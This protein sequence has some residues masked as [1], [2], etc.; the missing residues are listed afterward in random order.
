MALI[1]R[2][3]KATCLK[4]DGKKFYLDELDPKAGRHEDISLPE[5]GVVCQVEMDGLGVIPIERSN[6]VESKHFNN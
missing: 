5:C 2:Q 6:L 4:K 1:E 3:V